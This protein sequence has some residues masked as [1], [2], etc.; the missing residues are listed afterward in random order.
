MG[1]EIN[2]VSKDVVYYKQMSSTK[3]F[4]YFV[5]KKKQES[6]M[7]LIWYVLESKKEKKHLFHL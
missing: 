3:L 5:T 2:M 6:F 7:W 1:M 4:N